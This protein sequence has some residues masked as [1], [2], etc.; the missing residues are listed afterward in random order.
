[1]ICPIDRNQFSAKQPLWL[2]CTA[3][4]NGSEIAMGELAVDAEGYL[5]DPED[6]TEDWAVRTARALDIELTREH[7]SAIRFM[8]TFREQHQ[9]SPDVRFVIRHLT[10]SEGATRNRIFELFPYGYAGQAC[11]IAGMKRPRI[12]STG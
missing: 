11:K 12:W 7:W 8:R 10:E 3:K 5:V 1:M 6:W 9:V 2:C 4:K